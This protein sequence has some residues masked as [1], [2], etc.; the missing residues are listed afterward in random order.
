M[1]EFRLEAE[2][3]ILREWREKDRVPFHAM[4]SDARVMATL[5]PIM[6]REESDALIDKVQARQVEYG[7]TVWALER[8]EDAALLGWC[9]IVIVPDGLPLAGLPEIGWRLAHHAW[10]QGYAREAATASLDWAFGVQNMERMW[11]YTS[12]GND[13]SWGLME[14]L[15]MKRHDDMD[16]EHPN[17]PDGS[18][19]KRHITYSIGRDQ[20]PTTLSTV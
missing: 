18:P 2:R 5:G 3:L 6:K 13:A 12:V 9:G 10:G 11:A 19:L 4:S 16:F 14:R 1:G 7:H 17:V 20:W 15:G 8:K